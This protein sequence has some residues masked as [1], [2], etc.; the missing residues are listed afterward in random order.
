LQDEFAGEFLMEPIGEFFKQ[1][2]EVAMSVAER[3]MKSLLPL[4]FHQT[5]IP[6]LPEIYSQLFSTFI[7]AYRNAVDHGIESPGHRQEIGK[8]AEGRIETFF[9]I[10]TDTGGKSWLQIEVNDDGGGIDPEK[11]RAKLTAQGKDVSQETDL[12]VI[13]HIFDSQFSTKEVVTETSGRGVGMDAILYAAKA[14]GGT[15]W[16]NSTKGIGTSLKIRVPYQAAA[17]RKSIAA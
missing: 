17:T 2:N 3:E 7:H 8:P 5:D 10:E 4:A 12:Q 16:V 14:L 11:I 9:A 15:A 1:Y 13:Q 6:V